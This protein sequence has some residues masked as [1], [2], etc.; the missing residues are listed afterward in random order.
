MKNRH[1]VNA[2][3]RKAVLAYQRGRREEAIS[4]FRRAIVLDPNSRVADPHLGRLLERRG[5]W[6]GAAICYRRAVRLAPHDPWN[7]LR[8]GNALLQ[9]GATAEAL[10][11]YA[12]AIAIRPDLAEAHTN[13][14]EALRRLGRVS[15]AVAASE[16][17]L[18]LNP[19]LAEAQNNLGNALREAGELDTAV[20]HYQAALLLKPDWPEVH[21][22]LAVALQEQ[23]RT[24]EAIKHYERALALNP[25]V[26][27]VHQNLGGALAL[28]G[29]FV[30]AIGALRRALALR[31][32]YPEAVIQIAYLNGELCDWRHRDVEEAR[33]LDLMREHAG[34][35]PPFNLQAQ[36]STPAEQLLCGQ[37]W[38]TK[39]A[40]AQLSGFPHSRRRSPKRVRLGYLSAD[41]RDHPVAYAITETIERHDRRR[42]EI[43]GYSYGPNDGSAL[44][45]RLET[46]FDRFIDLRDAANDA[47]A[48]CIHHDAIDVL[49][50]LTGYT[51][52]ARPRI[53]VARPAPIQISFLGFLGTMGAEFIDYIVVDRF[54]APAK[55]QRF[56][57][58]KLVHLG[59]GWWPAAIRWE[60]ATDTR[61]RGYYGLPENA[62]VF[63]CF[64]TSYKI[65]PATFDVWMRLLKANP[66]SVLWLGDGPSVAQESLRREAAQRGIGFERLVFAPREP[67][68]NYLARHRHADLFL[69][70]VPYNAVG[71]A[72]HALLAGL[73]V[74]TYAGRTFAS[75]T[76]G[77]ILLTAGLPEL[78]TY[79]LDE[80]F[81][82]A[83]ELAR[84]TDLLARVR[85]KV[86]HAR[87]GA[88]FDGERAVRELETA[89]EHMWETW[90]RGDAPKPFSVDHRGARDIEP[91]V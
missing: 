68:A 14:G 57:S 47:A 34:L 75:R 76:A 41:F 58:E 86:R 23:G 77:S 16:R 20:L 21:N 73:P 67:I 87:V 85:E 65:T 59:G 32:D 49:I 30:E 83:M 9:E 24:S 31:A 28:S 37:Q 27:E 54:I 17:A 60:I 1:D 72:Y 56:Y 11:S 22:N 40:R 90:L 61:T 25:E 43:S 51:R 38:S 10:A 48:R 26:A 74:L 36:Q 70:T 80:Y 8:L 82:Q 3:E 42:F 63:C 35:V 69:D 66:S 55:E 19:A 88:L 4:L 5:D 50:D 44:R 15:E 71:T 79:S 91:S 7:H 53:L 46:A 2:I 52:L 78:V 39:I 89:F 45:R 18:A 62:F 84:R 13:S 29:C 64:N 81:A 6:A 33:T 12:S